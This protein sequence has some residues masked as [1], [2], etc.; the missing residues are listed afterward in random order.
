VRD[1]TLA[2]RARGPGVLRNTFI[3]ILG[4]GGA[5]GLSALGGLITARVLGPLGVGILA[6]SFGLV[7][8]GRALS[9]FT[10]APSILEYHRGK[11]AQRVFGTSL[12]LKVG[13]SLVFFALAWFLSPSLAARFDVPSWAIVLASSSLVIGAFYEIGSAKH[14]ADNR[15]V[16]RNV[17]LGLGPVV[18]L[19]LVGVLTLMGR[20]T[21]LTSVLTTVAAVATMSLAFF[22]DEPR[23]YRPRFD[24]AIGGY[25]FR[26]GSRIVLASLLTQGLLWTDTLM[27][28]ILLG[29][30][31][32]GIYNIVFQITYVMVTASVAIGVALMPALSELHG[33]GEDTT[34][35][36]QRGTLIAFGMSALLSLFFL[37]AGPFIL[38]LYGPG[39]VEGA[40]ALYVLLL[41]GMAASLAVPASSLLTVHGHAGWMTIISFAQ[42]VVNIP[43]N[44]VLIRSMGMTG[45]AVATT[46][47]FVAGTLLMWALVRRTTG[48]TPVSRAVVE[49]AWKE[50]RDRIGGL[51]V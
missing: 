44:Y 11:G 25:L 43:L 36:F 1:D 34:V 4:I 14:E 40:S 26:Y 28:S 41:F 50:L 31:A 21:V 22:I 19:V 3:N 13:G 35:G 15:M 9:N 30:V 6:V 45:A 33:R 39:F 16:R 51:F 37:A 10:H 8:F 17:L 29:N 48:A 5:H 20:L 27:V 24:R 2:E 42:L 49:E 7:E 38:G 47:V 18:G 32:T 23:I 46:C 12:V